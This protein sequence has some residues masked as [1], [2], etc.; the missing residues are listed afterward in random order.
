M[1][2]RSAQ[3]AIIHPQSSLITI[4]AP[5]FIDQCL[6]I[7]QMS[8]GPFECNADLLDTT[9][10][11]PM[12]CHSLCPGEKPHEEE[13]HKAQKGLIHATVGTKK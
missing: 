1:L 4:S 7:T 6:Y 9:S 10:D 3:A 8:L 12:S 13:L 5:W 11:S 2:R